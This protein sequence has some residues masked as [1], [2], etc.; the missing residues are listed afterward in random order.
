MKLK[1]IYKELFSIENYKIAYQQIKSKPG[2]MTPGIDK[3]TLHGM[4]IK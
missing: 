1:G 3:E 2:N 4:S